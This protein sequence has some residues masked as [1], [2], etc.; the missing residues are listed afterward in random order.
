[1]APIIN[2][3]TMPDEL[4]VTIFFPDEYRYVV[5]HKLAL[6]NFNFMN[7]CCKLSQ[8]EPLSLKFCNLEITTCTLLFVLPRRLCPPCR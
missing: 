8:M 4:E 1:M 3:I 2:S 7:P 5:F 6:V